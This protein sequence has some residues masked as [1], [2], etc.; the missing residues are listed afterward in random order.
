M[1]VSHLHSYLVRAGKHLDVQPPPVGTEVPKQG[2]L[3]N[4]LSELFLRS[5][6]E[7]DIDIVFAPAPDGTQNNS[8]RS[9]L[10]T[11]SG[12]PT[13]A[14]GRAIAERLQAVTT[15]R[16]GLGLLF[17]LC[18]NADDGS[19]TLVLSRFPADSG[20]LA[21]E[22]SGGLTVE[23]IERVFMRSTKAYKSAHFRASGP[24]AGFDTGRAVDKQLSG[25]RDLSEYW[26]REFLT[27]ELRTT[28][29]AGTRR[30]AEALRH[31]IRTTPDLTLKQELLAAVQ[32]MRG[33]AGKTRSAQQIFSRL[34]LSTQAV[35]AMS[36]A[37][38]R[39]ELLSDRFAFD[40]DEFNRHISF[41][42]VELD[43]GAILTADDARFDEVFRH[44]RVA[45]ESRVRY[46]T[47]GVIV[48]QRLRK[49]K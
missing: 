26:I 32:L 17:I 10:Q 23:F 11:Y 31:A 13:L 14:R 5:A 42:T 9:L 24:S 37:Y 38:P 48:D 34:G 46:T 21:Q 15:N 2:Q 4:M 35:D 41:R 49:N 27:C 20:V 36:H 6:T 43:N 47:E 22:V 39:G 44:D 1:T 18:G 19:H 40:L 25:P 12:G 28:G 8:L 29:P 16:S 45:A 33:Q 7:C 30:L 3:F